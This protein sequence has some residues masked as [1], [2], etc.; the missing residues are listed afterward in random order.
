M[1]CKACCRCVCSVSVKFVVGFELFGFNE[2]LEMN[3]GRMLRW[4]RGLHLI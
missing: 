2:V 1:L 4:Q 3:Y